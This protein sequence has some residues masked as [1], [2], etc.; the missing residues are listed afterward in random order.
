ML[1]SGKR[2]EA[3]QLVG[4]SLNEN[5]RRKIN[6]ILSD[7]QKLRELLSSPEAKELM[8]KFGSRGEGNNGSA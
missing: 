1:K 4:S 6:S 8:K 2:E 7:P 5:Q 3:E